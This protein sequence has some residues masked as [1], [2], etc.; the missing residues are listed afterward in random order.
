MRA[1]ERGGKAFAES[2]SFTSGAREDFGDGPTTALAGLRS[3]RFIA[4]HD[5]A[6][7]KIE[8]HKDAVSR[9]LYYR[10]VTDK[11]DRGLLIHLTADG[12]ITDYDIVED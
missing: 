6:A 2:R 11:A 4:E 12:T 8:R 1:L 7:R 3:L 9:I 10:L 5:V